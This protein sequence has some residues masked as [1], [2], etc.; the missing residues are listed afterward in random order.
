M[1]VMDYHPPTGT[2]F[3][4]WLGDNSQF[5]INEFYVLTLTKTNPNAT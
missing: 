1:M 4:M 5:I 3:A 2:V